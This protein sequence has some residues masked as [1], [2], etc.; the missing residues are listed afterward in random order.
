MPEDNVFINQD[1]DIYQ[2]ASDY[3]N[4][5]TNPIPVP[6]KNIGIETQGQFIDKVVDAGLSS[7]LDI[8]KIESF[9][10][11][12]NNRET[13][14]QL[15]DT[16][17]EDSFMAAALELYAED[18]TEANDAGDIVWCSSD[19]DK[20]AKYVTYLIETMNINKNIYKWAYS[21]CKYGDVYLRLYRNSEYEDKL[22]DNEKKKV[23][24]KESNNEEEQQLEEKQPLNEEVV[25][26]VYSQNDRYSH[27]V[28]MVPNPA[29]MF[30]L[31]K[32][33]KS[34][35]YIKANIGTFAR[36]ND[37][38]FTTSYKYSF[39]RND[40]EVFNATDFVHAALEDN[41]SRIPEEVEIFLDQK[42]YKSNTNA[43][44]YTVRR[45]QSILYPIFKLWR[46]MM[47]L[48]N[49]LLL[50]RLTKSSIIR[51]IGV[52]V[53]DMPKENIG[54]HLMGIKQLLEQKTALDVNNSLSEYTNPG[55]IENNVYIPT[56]NG[57]GALSIQTVNDN[58]DVNGL[59]DID[60]FKNK[61]YAALKIPKA[62]LGDTDDPG[63]FNG[64]TSLSLQSSRYA[65]TIKR[66][67]STLCQM[68]TDAV[69]L[70]LIDKGLDSYV[71]KFD[72]KMQAPT[73]Q[74][75][76]DRQDSKGTN[77]NMI[78]DIMNLLDGTEIENASA[79]LKILKALLS[80]TISDP[81]V[82]KIIQDQIDEMESAE[83]EGEDTTDDELRALGG[84]DDN[85][86]G[87]SMHNASMDIN[88]NDEGPSSEQE[89]GAEEEVTLPS[90]N[91]LDAGDF[92]DLNNE[93]I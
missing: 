39:A 28:E 51:V 64:G 16:M 90:P 69:N 58:P 40:V 88:V 89:L 17:A 3:Y 55:P 22:F 35:G 12:S 9:T 83:E 24:L 54:P 32:F 21:L 74:E 72:I 11:I 68:I 66:I 57:Q 48:E 86:P 5:K 56:H 14:L 10:Q 81:E 34:C 33:G 75:E 6:E 80:E 46:M 26:K 85:A 60:Y 87:R 4:Q 2:D 30:E 77:I 42:D 84:I 29:E 63:G 92:T 23:S 49:S 52:E 18:A 62:F 70:M 67:Q 65:K 31:T 36:N 38:M 15:L 27:Y 20:I 1:V 7:K 91:E 76:K 53:G 43:L 44:S 8:A 19:N 73:T 13:I 79:K 37:N 82:L 71:N 93:L 45:G 59:A 78:Q 61:L 25:L 41:T 50:N 47:L